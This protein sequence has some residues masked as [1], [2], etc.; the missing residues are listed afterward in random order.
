VGLSL[1]F[2]TIGCGGKPSNTTSGGGG[3]VIAD[4]TSANSSILPE[5]SELQKKLAALEPA[6]G[7]PPSDSQKKLT[8]SIDQ[9]FQWAATRRMY[10]HLDKPMYQP[11][12]TMWFRIWEMATP[13]LTTTAAGHGVTA[14][15]ISPKG[16]MVMQKR[17]MVDNEQMTTNDFE[18]PDTVQGGEYIVRVTSDL[19]GAFDRKV[20][21]SQYQPPQIKK[22]LEFLRKAYGAGDT[23]AAGLALHRGTGEA[24][25]DKTITAIAS[26][27]DV[28]I[29]RF[30][31]TTTPEGNAVVKFELPAKIQRGDGLLTILVEDA[32]VTESI[33]KRI[34]I[35]MKEMEIT[36]YPEGGDLVNG[37]P[38]RLYFQA[39]NLMGKPADIEGKI[40]NGAGKT[41]TKFSSFYNGLGRFEIT[42][43]SAD[44]YFMVVTKPAGISH[45]IPLPNAVAEGCSIQAVDDPDDTRDDVRVGIWCSEAQS[46]V[47]TAVLR[48]KRLGDLAVNVE[49]GEP[50]VVSLPVP[51]GSQGAVRFTL[52]SDELNPIAERLVYRGRGSDL[53]VEISTDKASYSPRDMVSMTVETT[54][55][56][57]RPVAADLSLA[58]VND[59]VLSFADDK[60]AHLLSRI[61]LEGEMPG[62]EIEEPNFYFSADGKAAHGIDLVLGTQ[63]WRRFEWQ[64]VLNPVQ[65]GTASVTRGADGM[66]D[67]PTPDMAP[68]PEAMEPMAVKVAVGKD[69]KN[70]ERQEVAKKGK[71][72]AKKKDRADRDRKGRGK[73]RPPA[74]NKPMD[75][76][77]NGDWDGDFAAGGMAMEDEEWAG[78]EMD[79][80]WAWAPVRVFPAPNYEARYDGPRVDFRETIHWAPSVKTNSDGVAK[81]DFYLSDQVTS[82]RATAEGASAGGLPG[83]G[84]TLV[85]SKLPVSLAVKMPLEVS[86]G[87]EIEL[88]VSLVNET[89]RPYKAVVV[90]DFGSAFK[91]VKAA[92]DIVDLAGGERKAF[93]VTLEVVGDGKQAAAGMAKI[94]INTANL[95]DEVERTIKVVPLGFPQEVSV[96]GT[97]DKVS[98]HE[99]NLTGALPG[100]IAASVTMY[101]SPLATMVKGTEAII[102]EP[103]G[104]FEQASS[105]NYPNIMVLGYLEEN[106]AADPVLIERTMTTLDKGYKMIAG[107]ESPKD[108][109][110]WFG[111][112]PGHEAL[113]AYGL[114]EFA[115]M[116]HVYGDVDTKM[117]KR[118]RKWLLSRRDGNGGFKRN[119]RALDSFGRASAE[120][121]NGY[122]AYA[123]SEAGEKKLDKELAYQKKI[124]K[125]SKDP[126]LLALATNTIISVEGNT[127]SAKSA[128]DKLVGLQNDKGA[129]TGSDHSITRSGGQALDIESTSIAVMALL[130]AGE[131]NSEAARNG[132]KWLNDNRDGFGG[133]GST[134]STILALKAMT[135]YTSATKVTRSGGTATLYVNGKQAGTVSFEKG[136]KDALV[137]DDVAGVLKKGKNTIELRLDSENPLP[138]SVAIEY[139]TAQP[140]SSKDTAVTVATELVKD[141]VPMGEGVRMNVTVENITDEGVPMT[142]AR[143]GIPG[144]LTFQVWQLKELKDKGIIDFFET[145]EREVVLYFRSMAPNK[146]VD[147]PLELMASVPG[148]FVAPA[149]RAYLYY[150]D[151]HKNWAS[152]TTITINN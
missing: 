2:G 71:K 65:P 3:G 66:I 148:T 28:E 13:T 99:V 120:V 38:S 132:I 142:L 105:S 144:G 46:V 15:L 91:V 96:S 14:Q 35:L 146:K 42:P 107:Y 57:G 151:E 88:P 119:D 79:Q 5:K 72:E 43:N 80:Q 108:G 124:A 101:P 34:P 37:L 44:P 40:V 94:G 114:M 4:G 73:R 29:A 135:Q 56:A 97:V 7:L 106:D 53:K 147:I 78:E 77:I 52:F 27:D 115:D 111:G 110:E 87:D 141:Q 75:A 134:Q 102:R 11:G 116:K 45:K 47:A 51:V 113:T 131:E 64:Q 33:Q 31:L 61:Y 18:L 55:L 10:V 138:Y 63:G 69:E 100:T 54:D 98:K 41:I 152:P 143:V 32:G 17:I 20:M 83:R 48:E 103:Y 104:C 93:F 26:V 8:T 76:N 118:T 150:T 19:G 130:K 90:T 1:V 30:D 140:A 50:T 89:E 60:T 122:I 117:I 23:V 133:Y 21:V 129:W 95:K 12:E 6:K 59:T 126:Y 149:S 127:A 24:L 25:S 136:H 62:Q 36:M 128:L 74:D 82:F 58:V 86:A 9:Y 123:L 139:R 49:V 85:Q 92:P 81:V 67:E 125:S 39:K 112:D 145:R 22:K 68:P 70:V 121:T 84:E 16:A 109:Y 137:F